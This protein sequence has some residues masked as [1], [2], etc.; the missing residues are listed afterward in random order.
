MFKQ[1]CRIL[2]LA[3]AIG[4]APAVSADVQCPP[5]SGFFGLKITAKDN[6]LSLGSVGNSY[7]NRPICAALDQPIKIRIHNPSSSNFQVDAGDVTVVQ[8]AESHVIISGSND[9]DVKYLEITVSEPDGGLDPTK[10]GTCDDDTDDCAGFDIIV[11]GLGTLDPKVRVV[12]N[13]VTMRNAYGT[14][15]EVFED[16]DMTLEDVNLLFREFDAQTY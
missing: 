1:V 16:L 3:V 2:V 10:L 12:D 8:K 4:A 11:A 7:N 5:T 13:N 14:L 6:H 9:D 15:V